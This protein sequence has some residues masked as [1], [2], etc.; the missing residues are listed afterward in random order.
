MRLMFQNSKQVAELSLTDQHME[1][2]ALP[3]INHG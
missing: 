3:A 1:A 2:L